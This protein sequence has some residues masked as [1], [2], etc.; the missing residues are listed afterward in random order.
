MSIESLSALMSLINTSYKTV[1]TILLASGPATSLKPSDISAR[2]I[3]KEGR[4]SSPSASLNAE[5][6]TL[7]HFP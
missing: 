6:R 3:N 2:V 7:L 4:R 1:A 5:A